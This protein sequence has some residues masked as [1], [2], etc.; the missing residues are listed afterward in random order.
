MQITIILLIVGL[1]DRLFIDWYWVGKTKAWFIPGT[2]DLVDSY[3]DYKF[4]FIGSVK[5]MVI[6]LPVCLIVGVLVQ[7]VNWIVG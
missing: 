4:H 1:F 3:K 7:V 6:G 5:G 2:E